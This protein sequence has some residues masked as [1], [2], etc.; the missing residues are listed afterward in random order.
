MTQRRGDGQPEARRARGFRLKIRVSVF[1]FRPRP[2]NPSR[3]TGHMQEPCS[4]R[5]SRAFSC[6]VPGVRH[7]PDTADPGRQAARRAG[8]AVSWDVAQRSPGMVGSW[9]GS[10]DQSVAAASRAGM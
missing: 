6:P 4:V 1:R 3:L 8:S 10:D 2:P 7:A 5:R 9:L